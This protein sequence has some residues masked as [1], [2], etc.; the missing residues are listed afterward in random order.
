MKCHWLSFFTLLI[1]LTAFI[2]ELIFIVSS[3]AFTAQDLIL[4]TVAPIFLK[5]NS[6]LFLAAIMF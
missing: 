3:A 2:G 6:I 5:C 4:K 1:P